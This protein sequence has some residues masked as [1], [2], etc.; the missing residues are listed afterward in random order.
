VAMGTLYMK[1]NEGLYM[2]IIYC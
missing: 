1:T 2:F